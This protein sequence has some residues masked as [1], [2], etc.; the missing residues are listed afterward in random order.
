VSEARTELDAKASAAGAPNLQAYAGEWVVL[1]DGTVIE[2]GP[3]LA[4]IAEKARAQGI[5]C[6]RVFYV[7]PHHKRA[8]KLG[9]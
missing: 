5:R 3:D 9:L 1:H 4:K 8:V 2:H 6:P 7:E